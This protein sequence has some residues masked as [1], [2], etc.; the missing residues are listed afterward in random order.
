MSKGTKSQSAQAVLAAAEAETGFR[1]K[2]VTLGTNF[3]DDHLPSEDESAQLATEIANS[4][5]RV[6]AQMED[7]T[8]EV[9]G[10][11]D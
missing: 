11:E 7:G 8:L 4:M 2:G 10:Y 5:R 3:D 1:L 9:V 6:K